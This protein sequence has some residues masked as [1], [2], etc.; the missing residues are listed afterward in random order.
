MVEMDEEQQA[1]RVDHDLGIIERAA[2]VGSGEQILTITHAPQ[3]RPIAGVVL[4][5][6]ILVDRVKA[7]RAEVGLAR[8]LAAQGIVVQRFH[9]RGFGHSDGDPLDATFDRMLDDARTARRLLQSQWPVERVAYVGLRWGALFATALA[10]EESHSR[11]ETSRGP[12]TLVLWDPV[13]RSRDFFREA[14]RAHLVKELKRGDATRSGS[15]RSLGDQLKA[16]GVADILGFTVGALL[17]D[18]SQDRSLL[19]DLGD[20]G[21]SVLV[22]HSVDALSRNAREAIEKW[23]ASGVEVTT[24]E[25]PSRDED[26]WFLADRSRAFKAEDVIAQTSEWLVP[27]LIGVTAK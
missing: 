1:E 5:P 15:S 26:W 4:C 2:F 22:L 3:S 25:M 18:S 13:A 12:A 6:S 10:A 14:S 23:R 8:S 9:Y 20:D 7:Y 11:G 27:R 21:A 16:N 24:A 19:H 17:H